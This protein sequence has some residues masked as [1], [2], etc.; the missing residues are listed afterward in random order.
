ML[1]E[2]GERRE[3]ERENKNHIASPIL[4]YLS[5]VILNITS[6]KIGANEL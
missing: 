1:L 5:T 2:R 3:K 6:I 4:S